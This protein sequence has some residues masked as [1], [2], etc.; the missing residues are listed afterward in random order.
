M[1]ERNIAETQC[2]VVYLT[3]HQRKII[4]QSQWN[5]YEDWQPKLY[6]EVYANTMG[7]TFL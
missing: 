1:Q 4:P 3:S 6:T 5:E 7:V 2:K